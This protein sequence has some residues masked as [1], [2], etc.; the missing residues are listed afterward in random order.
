MNKRHIALGLFAGLAGASIVSV[1]A[2]ASAVNEAEATAAEEAEVTA[3][4][5]AEAVEEARLGS[6]LEQ[7]RIRGR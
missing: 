5:A 4:E 7:A 1:S 6:V 3:D 2:S